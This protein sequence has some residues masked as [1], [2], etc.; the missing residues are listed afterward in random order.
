M[1]PA[2]WTCEL[3]R[4]RR[5]LAASLTLADVSLGQKY[6]PPLWSL[7]ARLCRRN[8]NAIGGMPGCLGRRGVPRKCRWPLL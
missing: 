8:L 4:T 5:E 2:D 3:E 7:V 6:T 1:M